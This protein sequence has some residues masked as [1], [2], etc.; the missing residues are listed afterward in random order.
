MTVVEFFTSAK[1]LPFAK[2]PKEGAMIAPASH[3]YD[4][5]QMS[6]QDMYE[7]KS[8]DILYRYITPENRSNASDAMASSSLSY[9]HLHSS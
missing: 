4:L 9:P 2:L 1:A 5:V 3:T 8:R 6:L 7:V